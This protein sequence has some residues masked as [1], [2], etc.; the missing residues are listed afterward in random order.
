LYAKSERKG[1]IKILLALV[2]SFGITLLVWYSG[3]L[4]VLLPAYANAQGAALL[5]RVI[6][7]CNILAV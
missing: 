7:F 6:A 2:N 5:E 1:R 3:A 4:K